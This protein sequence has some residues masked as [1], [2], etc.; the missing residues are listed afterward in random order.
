MARPFYAFTI[1]VF[2]LAPCLAED[3]KKAEAR[4]ALVVRVK[5]IDGLI[6]DVKYLAEVVG[7]G[8]EANQ[9]E[10][11]LKSQIGEEGFKGID[12][13]KP[14]GFYGL[15]KPDLKQ[16]GG[17]ALVPVADE[18]AVLDLLDKFNVKA[19]KGK[20]GIY[21][22]TGDKNK[23]DTYFRFA[24][25]YLYV[26]SPSKSALLEANLLD[27]AH[28]LGSQGAATVSASFQFSKIPEEVKKLV[29]GGLELRAADIKSDKGPKETEA[30]HELKTKLVDD[31]AKRVSTLID[32][33]GDLTLSFN[34]DREAKDLS[35]DVS[36]AGKSGS[37]LAER[38]AELGQAKSLFA[39]ALGSDSALSLLLHWSLPEELRKAAEPVIDEAVKKAMENARDDAQR[40]QAEKFFKALEPTFKSGELDA[41][42]SLR[43]PIKEGTYTFVIGVKLKD[44]APLNKAVQDL[45][46]ALPER[47]QERIKLGAESVGDVK[48]HKLDVAATYDERARRILGD[49]PVYLAIRDNA[50]VITGGPEALS[51]IKEALSAEPRTAPPLQGQMAVARLAPLMAIADPQKNK[52]APAAAKK[53]FGATSGDDKIQVVFSGGKELRLKF[54]V[55]ALVLKFAAETQKDS[56]A[57]GGQEK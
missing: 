38:I 9:F 34:I 14:L 53:V 54:S 36:L 16:I 51:T 8:E 39:G 4:P 12:T 19:E 5:P 32:D 41:G 23:V 35:F 17:V 26:A 43:G 3:I 20:D 10:Q 27:P 15:L 7:K 25:N 21:T 30:V 22:V 28:V 48:V 46:K 18:K 37:K 6:A 33:G 2:A 29:M 42:F 56:G 44:G 24:N 13:K 31:I 1:L 11:L 45:V 49:S 50:L 55:K 40:Q 47:D 57:D 52:G